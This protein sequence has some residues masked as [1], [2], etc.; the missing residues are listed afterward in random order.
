MSHFNCHPRISENL[1]VEAKCDRYNRP[2][3]SILP[4]WQV[5]GS[6]QVSERPGRKKHRC[7]SASRALLG[8]VPPPLR[9]SPRR[10]FGQRA[11]AQ[12]VAPSPRTST[13][14]RD[15]HS[16]A[17][18]GTGSAVPLS[19]SDGPQHPSASQQAPHRDRKRD[20]A[21]QALQEAQ[22]RFNDLVNSDVSR[23]NCRIAR[24][25]WCRGCLGV[26]GMMI[27]VM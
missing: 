19:H 17:A 13:T 9:P 10:P 16:G 1:D 15:T 18:G 7:G 4:T 23:V 20:R 3:H 6:S 14:T 2:H 26:V 21:M 27:R 5:E 11:G 8:R 22:Q 25:S 12:F 24:L